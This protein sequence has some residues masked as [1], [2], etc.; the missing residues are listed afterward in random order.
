MHSPK[1]SSYSLMYKFLLSQALKEAFEVFCNKGVAGTSTAELLA[2]YCDNTLKKGGSE[3]LSD[4]VIE[5]TLDK[6]QQ[7]FDIPFQFWWSNYMFLL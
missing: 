6:V 7:K 4:D 5:D 3:E 2:N 1:T